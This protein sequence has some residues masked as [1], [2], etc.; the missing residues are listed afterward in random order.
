MEG[1]GK[2]GWMD[3]KR[4]GGSD[5]WLERGAEGIE[6]GMIISRMNGWIEEP[7]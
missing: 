5:D 3:W 6:G 1:G 2:V 7:E 4:V